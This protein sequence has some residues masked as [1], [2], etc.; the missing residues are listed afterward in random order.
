MVVGYTRG[1]IGAEGLSSLPGM[2]QGCGPEVALAAAYLGSVAVT[3]RLQ[4]ASTLS[5][6]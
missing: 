3:T 4:A 1:S 5:L 2:L 6:S